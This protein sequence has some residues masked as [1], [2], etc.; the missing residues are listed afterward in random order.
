MSSNKLLSSLLLVATMLYVV[1]EAIA[2]VG[3][4]ADGVF[5]NCPDPHQEAQPCF[6]DS[7]GRSTGCPGQCVCLTNVEA[8][9]VRGPGKCKSIA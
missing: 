6:I 1:D 4:F 2:A 3:I 7:S 9:I 8:D 5:R